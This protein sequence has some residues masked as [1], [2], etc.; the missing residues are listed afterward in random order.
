MFLSTV[1]A[2]LLTATCA[3]ADP[4]DR[5]NNY[6]DKLAVAAALN[7]N[8]AQAIALDAKGDRIEAAMDAAAAAR[9]VKIERHEVRHA[10]KVAAHKA[11]VA[12]HWHKYH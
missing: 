10:A 9:A 7:G 8:I 2:L 1:F 4:G 5:I 3:I 6:Y 12:R 11:Y